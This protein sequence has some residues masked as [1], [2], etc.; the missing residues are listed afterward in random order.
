MALEGDWLQ[1]L[2]HLGCVMKMLIMS[3]T[4][5][6]LQIYIIG[7]KR[8]KPWVRN[9]VLIVSFRSWSE[10]VVLVSKIIAE[11]KYSACSSSKIEESL[12]TIHCERYRRWYWTALVSNRIA[13]RLREIAYCSH[14]R[15]L[16]Y[17]QEITNSVNIA[18]VSFGRCSSVHG[19]YALSSFI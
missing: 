1:A 6:N 5:A 15:S 12:K 17:S 11:L 3:Y 8:V 4:D 10:E 14:V 9:I 16:W 7:S 19:P 13:N 2:G 18:K